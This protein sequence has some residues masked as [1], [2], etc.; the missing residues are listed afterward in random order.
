MIFTEPIV[1][2]FSL[3][4]GFNFSVLFGF[5]DAFPLVFQGVYHF[6]PGFSG[7]T[8]LGI[9]LGVVLGAIT[10][11]ILDRLTF[12]K[13][14]HKSHK[15]GTLGV[16]AP[17]HRLYAAMMGSFSLP[18]GLFWFAWT[19]REEVH[20]ISPV[21]ASIPFAWGNIMIFCS[22]ALYLVDTYGPMNGASALAANGLVRYV[23]GAAFPLFTVQSES[24]SS[25]SLSLLY[26]FY[27]F[28]I[29]SE[30]CLWR[31]LTLA[32]VS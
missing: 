5:F 3:Y 6:S 12:R 10:V 29:L 18:I 9:G 27:S 32:S 8:F 7:L 21:L 24:S 26:L 13:E 2:F 1:F 4:T 16:V 14:H 22:A 15:A 25:P 17:E 28:F 31:K 19:A 23:S 11:I 20:W 30:V